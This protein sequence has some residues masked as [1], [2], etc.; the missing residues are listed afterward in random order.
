[1]SETQKPGQPEQPKELGD[2]EYLAG[3][4]E[5]LDWGQGINLD[6]DMVELGDIP[7]AK[8]DTELSRLEDFLRAGHTPQELVENKTYTYLS[9]YTLLN[10]YKMGLRVDSANFTPML[11]GF[12]E[13]KTKELFGL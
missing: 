10:Q 1:M 7:Q 11:E 5:D 6:P 2:E 9:F 8:L 3:Q 13:Q 4:V 12:A